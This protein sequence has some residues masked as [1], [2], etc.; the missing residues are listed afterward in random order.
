MMD[1]VAY[2]WNEDIGNYCVW[3]DGDFVRPLQPLKLSKVDKNDL[4]DTLQ[5]IYYQRTGEI[6]W[7]IGSNHE[8]D[9][10][11]AKEMNCWH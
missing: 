7:V 10:A 3:E 11:L 8:K 5:N 4:A 2:K 1:N 6:N 9:I